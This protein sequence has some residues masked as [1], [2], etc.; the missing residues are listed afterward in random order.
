MTEMVPDLPQEE[1]DALFNRLDNCKVYFEFGLGGSTYHAFKKKNIKSI[2]S[3]ES[4][5]FWIN[6][7]YEHGI[8]RKNNKLNIIYVNIKAKP[9]SYGFPGEKSTYD[10]WIKYSRAFTNLDPLIKKQ[11][12]LILIDGRFRVA[13]ALNL[14]NEINENTV[15]AFDDF[16]NRE[17]YH[18]VLE[19]YDVV[20]RVGRMAFFKKKNREAPIKDLIIKYENDPR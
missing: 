3:V 18:I 12:D 5:N 19:Y 6:K 2:Y 8:P 9:N 16:F 20:E 1:K 11:V 13:C 17:H 7:L 4:D 15:I 14:F 10:D